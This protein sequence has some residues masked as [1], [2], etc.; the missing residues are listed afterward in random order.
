MS[1]IP[2]DS[3]HPW[4]QTDV[5]S[6]NTK[7]IVNLIGNMGYKQQSG[8][9]MGINV[10]PILAIIYVNELDNKILEI[11]NRFKRY[12]DDYFAFLLSKEFTGEMLLTINS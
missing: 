3:S 9:A 2:R 8:L 12:I 4:G 1:H 6:P 11:S 10:A 7:L 5:S